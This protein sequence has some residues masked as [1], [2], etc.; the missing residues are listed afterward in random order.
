[1]RDNADNTASVD[2]IAGLGGR[3]HR[4]KAVRG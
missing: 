1:L 4:S 3:S 2:L